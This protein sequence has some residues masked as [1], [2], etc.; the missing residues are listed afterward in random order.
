MFVPV[1]PHT[2]VINKT[3]VYSDTVLP[4]KD[5][6]NNIKVTCIG[7]VNEYSLEHCLRTIFEANPKVIF[8][9]IQYSKKDNKVY[10]YTNTEI[11]TKNYEESRWRK[12]T[13]LTSNVQILEEI[14]RILTEEKNK[15]VD[16][17]SIHDV[18]NLMTKMKQKENNIEEKHKQR[19]N[20]IVKMEICRWG[21][22]VIYDFDYSKNELSIGFNYVGSGYDEIIFNKKEGDLYVVKSESPYTDKVFSNLCVSL[23]ELYDEFLKLREFKTQENIRINSVNSNFLV[24]ISSYGVSFYTASENN[25]FIKDLELF[26]PSYDNEYKYTC[27]SSTIIS[28]LKGNENEIFRRIFVKISD[29]PKWSQEILYEIRQKQLEQER[30]LEEKIRKQQIKQQ[31]KLE[32]KRK[33]FPFLKK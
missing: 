4:L 1:V 25:H 22:I 12:Y 32:L 19:C 15:D 8:N 27:N 9:T 18:S 24:N 13:P 33:L 11:T 30:I 28:T 26:L 29:C 2:R 14:K 3:V 31:K 17:I 10:F 21:Y 16:S 23:S 5:T 7:N 20:T 6:G